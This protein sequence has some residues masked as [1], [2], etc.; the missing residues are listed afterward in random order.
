MKSWLVSRLPGSLRQLIKASL[1][2]IELM[3]VRC[4]ARNGFLASLYY[5]FFSREFYREHK[6][7]LQGRLAYQHAVNRPEQSSALLR[8][9]IHRLE[10]GLIMRPR[11][12]TFATDYIGETVNNYAVASQQPLFCQAELQWAYD[13]LTEYFAVVTDTPV[14]SAARAGF[15]TLAAR[16]TTQAKPY[17][18]QQLP[19]SPVSYQQ[20]KTLFT[21]RRAVRWYLP[22][23][24][25]DK[26]LQQAISAAALA[27]SACNRQPYQFVLLNNAQQAEAAAAC[28]MGTVGFAQNLPCLIAVTGDLSAYPAERDR[29]V[30]YIDA[31]LAS[32][33]LM[34]A[35]ETL[36]LSSC[37]INWPD[38]EAR[39]QKLAAMLNLPYYQRVIMLLAVGYADPTGGIAYS[40]KKPFSLL[41]KDGSPDADRS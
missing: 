21:R 32:M 4:F 26:L 35:L 15:N 33:Q 41:L 17:P 40:Q 11:K 8:R 9:N 19:D 12:A 14:I 3:V 20:L 31:A 39:E 18:Y 37:P 30:I 27:P 16:E 1:V 28:A 7:V 10:K 23:P 22:D 6:A 25:P 34:L 29:H 38:I 24:V 5:T 2:A 36:G 13:V